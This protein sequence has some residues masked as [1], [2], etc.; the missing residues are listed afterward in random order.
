[1]NN[2]SI[3]IKDGML[4]AD[5]LVELKVVFGSFVSPV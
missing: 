5:V 2:V 3:K 1:V 4:T